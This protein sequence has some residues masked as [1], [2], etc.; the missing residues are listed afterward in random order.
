MGMEL[1]YLRFIGASQGCGTLFYLSVVLNLI[2]YSYV[3]NGQGYK[4]IIIL[5]TH[6]HIHIHIHM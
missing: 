1:N 5:S 3:T 2:W 6:I 4:S